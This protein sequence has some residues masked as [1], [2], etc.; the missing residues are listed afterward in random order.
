ME[1]FCKSLSVTKKVKKPLGLRIMDSFKV[2]A[3]VG[4][5]VVSLK[6]MELSSRL[7]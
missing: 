1:S 3:S 4:I 5:Q 7:L 2:G 6:K